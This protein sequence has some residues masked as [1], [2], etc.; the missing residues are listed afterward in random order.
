M[1]HLTVS[2]SGDD[3]C[4]PRQFDRGLNTGFIQTLEGENVCGILQEKNE[5]LKNRRVSN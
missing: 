1:H 4:T 3:F 2:P 5:L